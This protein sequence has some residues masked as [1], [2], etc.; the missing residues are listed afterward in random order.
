MELMYQIRHMAR[1]PSSWWDSTF[2]PHSLF[3]FLSS[4][5]VTR[6]LTIQQQKKKKKFDQV[7][8]RLLLSSPPLSLFFL[9]FLGF[10]F[11]SPLFHRVQQY[12]R[13][14]PRLPLALKNGGPQYL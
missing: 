13:R 7:T 1:S 12:M 14:P 11:S 2:A 3:S 4:V 9:F 5:C 10:Y 8:L 6:V